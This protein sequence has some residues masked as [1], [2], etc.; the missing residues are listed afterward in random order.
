[1]YCVG[2]GKAVPV[3]TQ[4]LNFLLWAQLPTGMT[5]VSCG[6]SQAVPLGC[7]GQLGCQ[8]LAAWKEPGGPNSPP[9]RKPCLT[10]CQKVLMN[11]LEGAAAFQLPWKGSGQGH[12]GSAPSVISPEGERQGAPKMISK[13]CW[14]TPRQIQG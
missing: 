9:P 6:R 13:S 4:D 5:L 10:F 3:F 12:C 11:P 2:N 8:N 7:W 1:M 14:K